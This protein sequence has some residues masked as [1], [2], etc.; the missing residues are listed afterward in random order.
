MPIPP[1]GSRVQVPFGRARTLGICVST[2]VANPHDTLKSIYEWVDPVDAQPAVST[3]L[4]QLAEWMS[5]YYHHPLGEV[6]AT[7]LPAAARRR[8]ICHHPSRLLAGY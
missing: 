7:V 6:L 8:R 2:E 3:E 1:V 5:S 4:L